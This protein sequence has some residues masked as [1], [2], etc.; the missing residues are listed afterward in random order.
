MKT[1]IRVLRS[2]NAKL[3]LALWI[4]LANRKW[5]ARIGL[6]LLLVLPLV[7]VGVH[8]EAGGA[9][10][11]K[12]LGL[13]TAPFNARTV[14]PIIRPALPPPPPSA[15]TIYNS[16]P[17]PLPPNVPSLGFQS[18]HTNELGDLIHFAS[19]ARSL[20]QITVIMSDWALAS[21]YPTF[22][23]ALGPSWNHPI[24]LNLY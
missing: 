20:T 23:G 8:V 9:K 17:A 16:I 19:S 10:E 13:E 1:V 21:D 18:D 12:L 6:S 5:M 4:M 24:T 11:K 15:T 14:S 3:G 7:L 22:P 2:R